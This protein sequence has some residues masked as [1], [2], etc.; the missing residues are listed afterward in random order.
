MNEINTIDD[1]IK[2]LEAFIRINEKQ[3]QRYKSQLSI[4]K[5]TQVK[6]RKGRIK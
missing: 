4:L 3:E 2:E 5:H 6:R 1:M